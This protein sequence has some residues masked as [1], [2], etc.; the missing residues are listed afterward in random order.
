M[1]THKTHTLPTVADLLETLILRKLS[2]TILSPSDSG[3]T[4]GGGGEAGDLS[5][6][7]TKEAR[8]VS[9]GTKLSSSLTT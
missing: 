5:S 2:S 3:P 6:S 4:P 1:S 7:S 8:D 9:L